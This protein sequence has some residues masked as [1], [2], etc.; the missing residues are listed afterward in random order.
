MKKLL[1]ILLMFCTTLTAKAQIGVDDFEGGENEYLFNARTLLIK[2]SVGYVSNLS[3]PKKL[4]A[5]DYS[6]SIMQPSYS[7]VAER[8]FPI[9]NLPKSFYF[10]YNF[11]FSYL[12]QLI[13]LDN[14]QLIRLYGLDKNTSTVSILYP[15]VGV[16]LHKNFSSNL[17]S[18]I[19]VGWNY[20]FYT[21]TE[22][23]F[24]VIP[25]EADRSQVSV[26]LGLRYGL[27]SFFSLFAEGG[28][29]V[30]Y[31]KMGLVMSF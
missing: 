27:N 29:D 4:T 6:I 10:A 17:E 11:S 16:S 7:I 19:N 8:S 3:I 5:D 23:G 21:S 13:T 20:L 28:Y 30:Q 15:G 25:S 1:L 22:L 2:A 9:F 31:L 14:Q 24:E 12:R 26:L 18:Y